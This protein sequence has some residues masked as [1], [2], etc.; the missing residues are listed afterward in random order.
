[1]SIEGPLNPVYDKMNWNYLQ[2]RTLKSDIIDYETRSSVKRLNQANCSST[3]NHLRKLYVTRNFLIFAESGRLLDIFDI[4]P[5]SDLK[6]W[7]LIGWYRHHNLFCFLR[8]KCL[9]PNLWWIPVQWYFLASWPVYMFSV[10][11]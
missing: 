7:L 6:F 1:M 5:Y 3:P 11:P 10:C 4:F 8:R 2:K 9:T